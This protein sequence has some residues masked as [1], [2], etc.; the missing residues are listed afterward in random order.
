MGA[1]SHAEDTGVFVL[2]KHGGGVACLA[3]LSAG[4]QWALAFSTQEAARGFVAATGADADRVLPITL[5]EW[6]GRQEE[7]GWPDLAID[8]DPEAVRAHPLRIEADPAEHDIR[9]ITREHVW[10]RSYEVAVRRREGEGR[11]T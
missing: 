10:G 9:C 4:R 7:K 11:R 3:D 1:M 8:P 5:G 6:F 2:M